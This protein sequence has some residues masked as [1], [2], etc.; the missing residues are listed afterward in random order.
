MSLLY[1]LRP[2]LKSLFRQKHVPNK[3]FSS[4]TS[5]HSNTDDAIYLWNPGIGKFKR[6]PDSFLSKYF[7]SDQEV[8]VSTGFAYQSKAN[9]YKVEKLWS[10]PVVAE[11]YTLIG[12][13]LT[14]IQC[15]G[16]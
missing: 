8:W 1:T 9:D 7:S 6:L 3:G 2:K 14:E 16:L 5:D 13:N 15:C 4:T 10:T 11:A 12:L